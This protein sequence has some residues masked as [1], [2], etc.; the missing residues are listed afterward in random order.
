MLRGCLVVGGL[1]GV[2]LVCAGGVGL[3]AASV[4]RADPALER[5][6]SDV[7]ADVAAPAEAVVPPA[8][9]EPLP[10]VSADEVPSEPTPA[11]LA[12]PAEPAGEPPVRHTPSG[13]TS[14]EVGDV[15]K[16][17]MP[18]IRACW[19]PS[20]EH[21]VAA[22]VV[23]FGVPASGVPVD[24]STRGTGSTTLRTCLE[25][26]FGALRFGPAPAGAGAETMVVNYPLTFRTE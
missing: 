8:A 18:K 24:V 14:A 6:G 26:A 3:V 10:E 25:K 1:L 5:G 19:Q 9:T 21:D 16:R 11:V 12:P 2:L 20:V 13:R 17:A 22:L 15:V 7:V 4:V 23:K